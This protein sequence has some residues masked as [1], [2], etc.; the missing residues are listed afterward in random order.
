MHPPTMKRVG[1]NTQAADVLYVRNGTVVAEVYDKRSTA[2]ILPK[3]LGHMNI[4]CT[5]GGKSPRAT[6]Y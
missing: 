4:R 2:T 5:S 1:G 6:T 3:L